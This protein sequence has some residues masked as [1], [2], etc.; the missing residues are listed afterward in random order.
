MNRIKQT[1][2][3]DEMVSEWMKD[4]KFK[5]E[6]DSLEDEF[7]LFDEL[8]KARRKAGLTQEAVAH[9]MGTKPPAVARIE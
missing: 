3:H 2:R 7:A 8:I 9:R 6:Y 4:P 5:A 1:K